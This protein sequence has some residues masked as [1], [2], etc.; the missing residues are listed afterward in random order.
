[1]P[2]RS[3]IFINTD[4]TR[5]RDFIK[6]LRTV[7]WPYK[8]DDVP[9]YN[10]LASGKVDHIMFDTFHDL[11]K[12]GRCSLPRMGEIIHSIDVMMPD[13]VKSVALC[14]KVGG[15]E[16]QEIFVVKNP[17]SGHIVFSDTPDGACPI[18]TPSLCTNL[19]IE[20][21]YN[22]KSF[23][24]SGTVGVKITQGRLSKKA[25]HR[26][27]D[28]DIVMGISA[29]T[30]H[31]TYL[32]DTIK[33]LNTV[34]HPT[35]DRVRAHIESIVNQHVT[36]SHI[37]TL[38]ANGR[39][40]LRS[41]PDLIHE[42]TISGISHLDIDKVVL[43]QKRCVPVGAS[44]S[45]KEEIT[46]IMTDTE[47]LKYYQKEILTSEEKDTEGVWVPMYYAHPTSNR[48]V[49][50]KDDCPLPLFLLPYQQLSMEVRYHPGYDRPLNE[51][52]VEIKYGFLHDNAIFD[53]AV[54]FA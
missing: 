10:A 2:K 15:N 47:Y 40:T 23:Q 11:S 48:V 8:N 54:D 44:S 37:D 6:N 31:N 46:T 9:H 17:K 32:R 21:I 5:L 12:N 51:T 35:N 33:E 3:T 14:A 20:V 29:V 45:R 50:S 52:T 39:L 53:K 36:Y 16:W 42:V 41:V 19:S 34:D 22:W 25:I 43:Y 38:S 1:M 24:T 7:K 4:D 28:E 30:L 13:K 26:Y 27:E 18:Y 49:F